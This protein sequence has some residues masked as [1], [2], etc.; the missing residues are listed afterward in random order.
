MQRENII[1]LVSPY[2]NTQ[3]ISGCPQWQPSEL[4]NKEGRLICAVDSRR[5]GGRQQHPVTLPKLTCPRP[6]LGD[7]KALTLQLGVTNGSGF[8]GAVD[9][10]QAAQV[11]VGGPA[12]VVFSLHCSETLQG[13][14]VW[15]QKEVSRETLQVYFQRLV[16]LHHQ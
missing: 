3:G 7:N 5:C 4:K 16:T 14:V 15:G 6:V 12:L 10:Q 9:G 8:L 11:A 2:T 1:A 13:D